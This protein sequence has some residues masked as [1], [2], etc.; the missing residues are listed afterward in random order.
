MFAV[1]GL[2]ILA[3]GILMWFI[4][5]QPFIMAGINLLFGEAV[6]N[7]IQWTSQNLEIAVPVGIFFILI[8]PDPKRLLIAGGIASLLAVILWIVGF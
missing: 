7:G 6:K 5:Q 8:G 3:S 4:S 2:A 1:I